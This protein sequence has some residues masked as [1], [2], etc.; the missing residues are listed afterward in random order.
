MVPDNALSCL[1]KI[2]EEKN[3]AIRVFVVLEMIKAIRFVTWDYRAYLLVSLM[4]RTEAMSS[5]A[6]KIGG[7]IF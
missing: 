1:R 6:E 5:F 7:E 2:L 4:L 3:G